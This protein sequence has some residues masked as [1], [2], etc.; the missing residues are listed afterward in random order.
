MTPEVSAVIVNH[1]SALEAA[2]CAASLREAFTREAI[3]GEI[4]LVDCASG[5]AEAGTLSLAGADALVLLPENRG[6]SGGVNA[7]LVRAR[8]EIVILCNADVVFRSGAVRA[9]SDAARQSRV[10]AAGPLCFWDA[11]SRLLL[12]PGF[13][14]G[15]GRDLLQLAAGRF[16]RLDHQRFAA[17]ALETLALW[18]SGGDA[19]HLTGA[20]LAARREVFDRVGRFDERFPFEYEESEWEDRVRSAGYVLRYVPEAK[21]HHLYARS[22]ARNPEAAARRAASRALYRRRRYGALGARLLEQAPAWARPSRVAH[23]SEPRIAALPGA[24]LA[25]SPNRSLLPFVGASLERDFLL[26]SDVLPSLSPGPLYLRVFR[27][28]DGEPVETYVWEK[29]A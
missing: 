15:F 4:V 11:E 25:L 10:G 6:Y 17:F 18:R 5:E 28:A 27:Q 14:P 12:P 8:A 9:L 24:S 22:A 26:P 21:V 13:A 2:A 7:G 23:L 20:V 29:A 1:R 19:P 3:R 16:P